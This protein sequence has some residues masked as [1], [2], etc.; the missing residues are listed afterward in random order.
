MNMTA[1]EELLSPFSAE[2]LA[3]ARSIAHLSHDNLIKVFRIARTGVAPVFGDGSMQL[4]AVYAP[5]L[6]GTARDAR[7]DDAAMNGPVGP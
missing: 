3:E 1:K 5:D 4:S 6:A 7:S 2:Q